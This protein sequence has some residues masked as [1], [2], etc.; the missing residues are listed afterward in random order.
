MS[1]TCVPSRWHPMAPRIL[2]YRLFFLARPTCIL[3]HSCPAPRSVAAPSLVS[4]LV[5]LLRI[6]HSILLVGFGTYLCSCSNAMVSISHIHSSRKRS[7]L[8]TFRIQ[9]T[10]RAQLRLSYGVV[11][12]LVPLVPLFR[13]K[14][15]VLYLRHGLQFHCHSTMFVHLAHNS[16]VVNG[17]AAIMGLW[18]LH[19]LQFVP[20]MRAGCLCRT[21]L[22]M[23]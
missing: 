4:I 20:I 16:I 5:L 23:P 8:L 12:L 15:F 1:R 10:L 9:L 3:L 21:A 11:A 13:L 17:W 22:G 18:N 19:S 7:R 6:P 2:N 14:A